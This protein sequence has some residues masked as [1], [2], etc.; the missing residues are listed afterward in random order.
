MLDAIVFAWVL[1]I[2]RVPEHRGAPAHATGV[3]AS[4][5][6]YR[7]QP[8]TNL[9]MRQFVSRCNKFIL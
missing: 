3:I 9:P 2:V 5:N 4:E 1:I 6:I 7:F 8:L